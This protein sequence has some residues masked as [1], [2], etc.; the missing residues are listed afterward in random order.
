MGMTQKM[1]EAV[2]AM[3]DRQNKFLDEVT[4]TDLIQKMEE[5]KPIFYYNRLIC[6]LFPDSEYAKA[7]NTKETAN[8]NS[9]ISK[10]YGIDQNT[11]KPNKNLTGK[12]NELIRS[13]VKDNILSFTKKIVYYNEVLKDIHIT[14]IANAV[15]TLPVDKR[16]EILNEYS[17][18]TFV[19]H[20]FK[21]SNALP[22]SRKSLLRDWGID[23][24]DPKYTGVN[25]VDEQLVLDA[26]NAEKC[27][28]HNE[29]EIQRKKEYISTFV[30]DWVHFPHAW[31]EKA[32][33]LANERLKLIECDSFNFKPGEKIAFHYLKKSKVQKSNI[34]KKSDYNESAYLKILKKK[35]ILP[36]TVRRHDSQNKNKS[37]IEFY[38]YEETIYCGTYL[39]DELLKI[40]SV[41]ERFHIIDFNG[42]EVYLS[43]KNDDLLTKCDNTNE[44]TLPKRGIYSCSFILSP[45]KTFKD[46]DTVLISNTSNS[47]IAYRFDREKVFLVALAFNLT[48]KQMEELLVHCLGERT[49]NYKDP[50]EVILAYCLV[51]HINVCER[52]VHLCEMYQQRS[53]NAHK[54]KIAQSTNYYKK[55]FK[56]IDDDKGL[57]DFLETLPDSTNSK[58]LEHFTEC[59]NAIKDYVSSA[60]Q[61]DYIEKNY[62]KNRGFWSIDAVEQYIMNHRRGRYERVGAVKYATA[63]KAVTDS[64][65]INRGSFVQFKKSTFSS[66]NIDAI[67]NGKI[68]VTKEYLIQALFIEYCL[69]SDGWIVAAYD[70]NKN[71]TVKAIFEDFEE[72]CN[73]TFSDCGFGELYLPNLFE[74]IIIFCLLS[75]S[76]IS[77]F[78]YICNH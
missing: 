59:C 63:I 62:E 28:R 10:Y 39:R 30:G 35:Q 40:N 68:P 50:Y 57:L 29:K 58:A 14:K 8:L 4:I 21:S 1:N 36:V 61:Q 55:M 17:E 31:P 71:N 66:R 6:T 23:Y 12:R 33:L 26:Y 76:P 51:Q 18:Q 2:Q 19:E 15:A 44:V 46:I 60:R 24:Y 22:E 3:Y 25:C 5:I 78:K 38:P 72:W 67:L 48:Y 20:K 45:N 32:L 64:F 37:L 7:I 65:E 42:E 74:R 53:K 49:I 34:L 52:Y 77:V 73:F 13:A 69:A 16:Q 41:E 27:K 9:E 11:G 70:S 56:N 47:G 54:N 43:S 75:D